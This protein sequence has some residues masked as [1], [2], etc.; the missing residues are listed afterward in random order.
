ME[1]SEPVLACVGLVFWEDSLEVRLDI[2]DFLGGDLASSWAVAVGGFADCERC[3]IPGLLDSFL[4]GSEC[5]W[6]GVWLTP[7]M[8]RGYSRYAGQLATLTASL[9]RAKSEKRC[10]L[11][12][13]VYSKGR[14]AATFSS[15]SPCSRSFL[16][17]FSDP[18]I[19]GTLG[20]ETVGCCI[21][22]VGLCSHDTS[23]P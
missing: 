11:M 13:N 8:V 2:Q 7:F 14:N 15:F 19:C 17:P 5:G 1:T 3:S 16:S 22:C 6:G 18:N 20:A 12:A 21:P 23:T 9:S 10:I 4:I